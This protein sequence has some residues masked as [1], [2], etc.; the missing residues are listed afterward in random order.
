MRQ[1]L[2]AVGDV[3]GSGGRVSTLSRGKKGWSFKTRYT[4]AHPVHSLWL[5]DHQGNTR[6]RLAWDPFLIQ[7]GL[8]T[9][10][11]ILAAEPGNHLLSFGI[12]SW[13]A[14]GVWLNR[15]GDPLL[16][17]ILGHDHLW[18][19]VK[20][21]MDRILPARERFRLTGT[22]PNN[23]L[24]VNQ[25]YWGVKN[26]FA[27]SELCAVFLPLP[28]LYHYWFSGQQAVEPT[29]LTTGQLGSCHSRA[30]CQEV[31]ERLGL[32]ADKMP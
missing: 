15:L 2:I 9:G 16:P 6:H 4:F 14:D 32:P 22:Y 13:G 18:D 11:G 19:E 1:D 12:D 28:S 31:F 20:D 27:A 5:S 17:A 23:Y 25:V 21:E 3:G 24:V 10:L 30:Y 29:W 26:G 7:A 8:V